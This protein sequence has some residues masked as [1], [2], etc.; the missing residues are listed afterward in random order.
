MSDISPSA[1][2]VTP[3]LEEALKNATADQIPIIMR[4]ARLDQN[5]VREDWDPSF[6]IP[7]EPETAATPR[8]YAKTIVVNGQKT[9]LEAATEADLLR[10]E[11]E[12]YRTTFSD[13]TTTHQIEQPRNERGQFT[14][15][16]PVISDEQKAALHLQFSL[17]QISVSDYIEKSGAIDSYLAKNGIEM[18]ELK[19]TVA[20]KRNQR[21][22]Q[23]WAQS[24][25]EFLHSA[26]GADW[27]G[28]ENMNIL[29]RLLE[30]NNLTDKPSVETLATVWAH[31]KTHGLAVETQEAKDY[32]ARKN[33][34]DRISEINSPYE[35]RNILQPGSGLF[36]AR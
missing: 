22:E 1:V 32:A 36:G 20:D 35:L 28:G 24:V 30:E 6:L 33:M 8:G 5:L 27:P 7:N 19:A 34:E 11:T 13:A 4:Q 12:F 31:M 9:I 23:S 10:A 25:E 15:T 2:Q 16:E 17:G 21:D 26:V 14:A 29:G 18:E 3:A